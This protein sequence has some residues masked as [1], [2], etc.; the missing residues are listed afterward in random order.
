MLGQA[1]RLNLRAACAPRPV[2]PPESKQDTYT[3]PAFLG[4]TSAHH[5]EK[6]EVATSPYLLEGPNALTSPMPTWGSLVLKT[7]RNYKW[8]KG[9]ARWMHQPYLYGV[10][11]CSA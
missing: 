11:G 7:I 1:R 10:P 6:L 8:T 3:T 9:W 4:V 2:L 5:R